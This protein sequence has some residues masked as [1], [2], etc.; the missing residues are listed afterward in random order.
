MK[1]IVKSLLLF[2]L[3][4]IPYIVKADMG[5]PMSREYDV[6]VT[7]PNGIDYY[8]YNLIK[9]GHYDTNTILTIEFESTINGTV[10]L[11]VKNNDGKNI[12]VKASDVM[13]KEEEVTPKS[14]GVTK[15]RKRKVL[16]GDKDLEIR[17]GPSIVYEE[18]GKV[19]ANTELTVEYVVL[20]EFTNIKIYCY[21]EYK[22]TK[23]WIYTIGKN[24]YYSSKDDIEDEYPSIGDMGD[25]ALVVKTVK[26]SCGTLEPGTIIKEYWYT[27]MYGNSS[28]LYEKG[29]CKDNIATMKTGNVALLGQDGYK[30]KITQKT[31][32]YDLPKGKKIATLESGTEIVQYSYFFPY[33]EE[34]NTYYYVEANNQKGWV[35]VPLD[36]KVNVIDLTE[37]LVKV[38]EKEVEE[39]PE[40]KKEDKKEKDKETKESSMDS[41]TII[42]ICVVAGVSL[43][44]GA[45]V[46]L[47]L[48]NKKG[49]KENKVEKAT[50]EEKKE[51]KDE[52][53][54]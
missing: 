12:N 11:N 26:T 4:L 37:E 24:A 40:E 51:T 23:G 3:L 36:S 8:D 41:K 30:G 21:V 5:M 9:I 48:V 6:V 1:K 13:L 31:D 28:I 15:I 39:E 17:K 38:P 14:E 19:P 47:L 25:E 54:E 53:K 49:K 2:I 29:D 46:T 43:A 18:I 10:Y 32:L 45:L 50:K 44:L 33:E 16:V 52:E 34:D 35:A 20:D 22:G 27:D 7:N 42:I